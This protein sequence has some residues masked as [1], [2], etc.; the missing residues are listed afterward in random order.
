[1]SFGGTYDLLAEIP[2]PDLA[3]G[4][5]RIGREVARAAAIVEHS[6]WWLEM[7]ARTANHILSSGEAEIVFGGFGVVGPK[8]L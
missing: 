8:A 2:A 1:V 4:C 7:V 3:S 5:D 6:G